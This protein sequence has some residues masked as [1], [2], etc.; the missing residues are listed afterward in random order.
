[1][2]TAAITPSGRVSVATQRA[3]VAH[4]MRPRA[5]AASAAVT[6]AANSGVSMPDVDQSANETEESRI[7]GASAAIHTRPRGRPA[8]A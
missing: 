8:V 5:W 6:A 1:M 3:V 7:H 4:P 2:G